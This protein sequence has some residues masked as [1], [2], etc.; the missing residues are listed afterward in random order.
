MQSGSDHAATTVENCAA[1]EKVAGGDK[2]P[3]A[4]EVCFALRHTAIKRAGIG[5]IHCGND[6]LHGLMLR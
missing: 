1:T 6:K 4:G 2:L 5:E 3:Y